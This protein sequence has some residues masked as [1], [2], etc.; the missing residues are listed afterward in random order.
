MKGERLTDCIWV[1]RFS[2]SSSS[3][4]CFYCMTAATCQEQ[5]PS[6]TSAEHC[7]DFLSKQRQTHET[8]FKALADSSVA[9]AEC[10][11]AWQDELHDSLHKDRAIL[12]EVQGHHEEFERCSRQVQC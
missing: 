6:C 3:Y 5:H 8:S 1:I 2:I 4:G 9:R 7:K 11:A 12:E 10:K